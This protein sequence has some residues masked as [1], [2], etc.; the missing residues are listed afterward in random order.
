MDYHKTAEVLINE[1]RNGTL[2]Q[3]TL[4]HPD[5]ISVEIEAAEAAILA[6]AE[7]KA[8]DKEARRKRYLK[9]KR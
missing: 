3:I 2:G 1:L 8:K 4:E 6:K 9:N 7:E 5:Q